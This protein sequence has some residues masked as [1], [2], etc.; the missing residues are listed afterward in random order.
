MLAKRLAL[1]RELVPGDGVIALLV[2]PKNPNAEI[3]IRDAEAAARTLGERIQVFCAGAPAEFEAAFAALGQLQVRALLIAPDG[4]FSAN[5]A[6]LAALSMHHAI[7]ASHE[8]RAFAAAG[9]LMSYGGSIL[10]GVR[11]TGV[12]T[13]RILKGERPANLP[14][15]QPTKFE[16]VINLNAAKAMG[17][18]IPTPLLALADEVI[19]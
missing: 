1:L 2:N 12:H 3:S 14:V 11:Q 6:Q 15:M 4:F 13:A 9:G 18:T 16:L 7:P 8:Y 17:L 19:E 5:A 10:K